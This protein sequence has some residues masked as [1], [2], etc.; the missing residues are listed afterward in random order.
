[1]KDT[2]AISL[3]NPLDT[4]DFARRL[5]ILLYDQPLR[6]LWLSWADKYI[7][8]FDWAPIVT[9]YEDAYKEAIRI[10]EKQPKAKRWFSLR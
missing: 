5:E 3:V 10:H 4:V 1:M 6:K 8:N 9:Q 7:K 2:G